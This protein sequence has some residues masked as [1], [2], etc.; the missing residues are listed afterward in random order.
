MK[1][2]RNYILNL[3]CE[4]PGIWEIAA[5]NKAKEYFTQ[6]V[7]DVIR[8]FRQSDKDHLTLSF[9]HQSKNCGSVIMMKP[10][11]SHIRKWLNQ[12]VA[13]ENV[14]INKLAEAYNNCIYSYDSYTIYKDDHIDED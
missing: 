11:T 8:K 7:P 10:S 2:I 6:Q 4:L 12:S 13:D 9:A 14:D 1:D 5:F 3:I